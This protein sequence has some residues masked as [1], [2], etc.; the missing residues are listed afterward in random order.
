MINHGSNHQVDV[1]SQGVVEHRAEEG[2]DGEDVSNWNPQWTW[3]HHD[4]NY[5]IQD[6]IMNYVLLNT[7]FTDMTECLR[8]S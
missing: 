8:L 5:L 2:K 3:G 4:W 7:S 1:D 6:E